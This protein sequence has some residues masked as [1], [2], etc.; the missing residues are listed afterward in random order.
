MRNSK[1]LKKRDDQI[2]NNGKFQVSKGAK[3]VERWVRFFLFLLAKTKSTVFQCSCLSSSQK[4]EII[5]F[6]AHL[7]AFDILVSSCAFLKTLS[8]YTK[9]VAFPCKKVADKS[10]ETS[11]HHWNYLGLHRKA[12]SAKVSLLRLHVWTKRWSTTTKWESRKYPHPA[13]VSAVGFRQYFSISEKLFQSLSLMISSARLGR[14]NA[15]SIPP[16]TNATSCLC[17]SRENDHPRWTYEC[18]YLQHF[19]FTEI[20]LDRFSTSNRDERINKGRAWLTRMEALSYRDVCRGA[21][22]ACV[23]HTNH[24]NTVYSHLVYDVC[25]SP[26]LDSGE[27]H[28]EPNSVHVETCPPAKWLHCFFPW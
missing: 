10:I 25:K 16:H 7:S 26:T 21:L 24:L 5:N 27:R 3:G 20:K 28:N 8:I 1:N 22:R 9:P 6:Y 2:H 18:T 23:L 12:K 4:V 11:K 14:C 15:S 17:W 19:C 13:F